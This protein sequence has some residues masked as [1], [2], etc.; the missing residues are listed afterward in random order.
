MTYKFTLSFFCIYLFFIQYS[1]AQV[2]CEIK[3]QTPK[4]GTTI[5]IDSIILTNSRLVVYK[6]DED[7]I[8][9]YNIYAEKKVNALGTYLS[10][11]SDLKRPANERKEAKDLA[12]KLFFDINR[13]IQINDSTHLDVNSFLNEIS[14]DT[15]TLN[16]IEWSNV[17]A[18]GNFVNYFCMK[19]VSVFETH[20]TIDSYHGKKVIAILCKSIQLYLLVEDLQEGQGQLPKIKIGNI[21]I[22]S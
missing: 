14:A 17:D 8:I 6:L 2:P 5:D 9:A 15:D 21:R 10:I 13:T 22:I 16:Y 4:N 19:N 11:I 18:P 3:I 12:N 20:S 7:E 1:I